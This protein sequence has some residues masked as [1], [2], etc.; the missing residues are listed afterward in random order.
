MEGKCHPILMM[1]ADRTKPLGRGFLGS[2]T[3]PVGR[4]RCS[5]ELGI[6]RGGTEEIRS[7]DKEATE[8]SPP[9]IGANTTIQE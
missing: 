1:P 5:Q 7:P 2:S 4:L 9:K 6:Q 8:A 3:V